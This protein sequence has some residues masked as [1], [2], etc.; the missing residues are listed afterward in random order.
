[1]TPHTDSTVSMNGPIS[2][3]PQTIKTYPRTNNLNIPLS[4]KAIESIVN[5][6]SK[7]KTPNPDS[8]TGKF[9]T[10]SKDKSNPNST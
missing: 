1:M 6:L 7:E 9:Y 10:I 5:D 8:F 4:T 2:W 3:N